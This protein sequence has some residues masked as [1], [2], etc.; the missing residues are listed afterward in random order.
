MLSRRTSWS[1]GLAAAL[2]ALGPV[3]G[4][5]SEET[6]PPDDGGGSSST[7]AGPQVLDVTVSGDDLSPLGK[8]V[9]VGIGQTLEVNIQADQPGEFHVHSKPEQEIA[10]DKGRSTHELTFDKP[11]VFPIE[12]HAL[13]KVLVTL[14]VR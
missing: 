7:S 5:A 1:V 8:R 9:E 14:E 11:G 6:S 3:A 2:I 13:G 10:Y 4:C 12:S